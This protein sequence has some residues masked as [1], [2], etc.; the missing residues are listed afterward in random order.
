MNPDT[1]AMILVGFQN[2]YFA[3]DGVLRGV[4]EDSASVD[5]VLAN[6]VAFI[7]AMAD[8][9]VTMIATPIVLTADYRA[10][11]N[12]VGIL[13]TMKEAGAFTEGSVGAKTIPEILAFGDRIQYVTGKVGFNAFAN[14]ALAD[15][16]QDKGITD[17][18][19]AGQVTS[20]CIDSTG[21]AAYERGYDVTILADC[22]SSRTTTEHDFFC[23]V[24]FPLYGRAKTTTDVLSELMESAT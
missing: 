18:L 15:V 13:N 1:T 7:T 23:D 14:T 21:R 16:L 4:V 9:G 20:L 12:P 17:V 6:T 3:Q 5:S 10:M 24:V 19:V 2:D 11:A 8:S 22:T